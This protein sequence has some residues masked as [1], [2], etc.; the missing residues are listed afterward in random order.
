MDIP[1]YELVD[2]L[3]AGGF[4]TVHRARQTAVGR[5]V[6]LKID[7]RVLATERDRRRFLR[8]VTAAGRLSGHPHVVALYDAGVLPDGR[9]FMVMELCPNGSLRDLVSERGPLPAAQVRDIGVRIASALAAAHD[10]GILH[11]DVKPANILLDRY[12]NVALADFGL[13]AMP[14]PG[15][16]S[17]ATR[18]ALTPAYA[19]PEAFRLDEPAPAGDVYSLAASLYTLLSGRPPHV[20]PDGRLSVPALIAAQH[21]PLPDLPGV[22]PALTAVLRQGMAY[23]PAERPPGAAAFGKAL[24]ELSPAELTASAP[25]GRSLPTGPFAPAPTVPAAP[26]PRRPAPREERA[27]G[28]SRG[29]ILGAAALLT[30]GVLGAGALVAFGNKGDRE[31]AKGGGGAQPTAAAVAGKPDVPVRTAGCPAASVPGA[32][33]ACPVTPECWGGVVSIAGD[34][35]ATRRDCHTTH[36]L[37][38]FAIAVMPK[39]GETWEDRELQQHPTVRRVCSRKVMLASRRGA[40]L[41]KPAAQWR[42]TILPP[43]KAAFDTG[44]RTYRCLGGLGLDSLRGSVFAS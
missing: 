19:P 25:T 34:A 21:R 39:D 7:G 42:F 23:D 29:A 43:S 18:E 36:S 44:A 24:A 17:S 6:A 8:E 15:L 13:A 22:P 10:A 28:L 38:T 14:A 5:E 4:G 16:E 33:A 3:G 30:A 11:R 12:G 32:K 1:G 41:R 27:G 20:P 31:E 9:P 37:E 35:R 40:A 26:A 2:V